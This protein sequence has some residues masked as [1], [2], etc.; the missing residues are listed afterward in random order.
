[1]KKRIHVA[2]AFSFWY[3]IE[4]FF[5]VAMQFVWIYTKLGKSI[6]LTEKSIYK[7]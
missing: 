2:S 5:L 1:M 7:L 3:V 6:S 4:R